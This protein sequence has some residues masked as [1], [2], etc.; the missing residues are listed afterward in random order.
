MPSIESILFDFDGTIIDSSV[1]C[2]EEVSDN[3]VNSNLPVPDREFI[4]SLW[5]I[6]F[7]K[8]MESI[9]TKYG[10]TNND[11]ELYYANVDFYKQP[12]KLFDGV[13]NLLKELTSKNIVLGIVSSR[14][15]N[16][17]VSHLEN[18]EIY[19]YFEIIQGLED[20]K[21]HKPDPR[22]FD[23][24]INSLRQKGIEKEKILFIGDT[25]PDLMAAR[26]AHLLFVGITSGA[27][28]KEE[29]Q[30]AG[31]SD[32]FIINN[33]CQVLDILRFN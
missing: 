17:M 25:L 26:N 21:V 30:Q 22:V 13:K 23:W 12:R 20:C 4:R 6:P 1:A 31:L 5:G 15:R 28:T 14:K 9:K 16:S 18:L 11:L 8:M 2:M 29:F 19:K 24:A 33:P 7:E 32:G 3:A 27:V 10:W